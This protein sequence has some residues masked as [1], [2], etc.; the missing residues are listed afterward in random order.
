M[1]S[2]KIDTPSTTLGWEAASTKKLIAF[3]IPLI[4][5]LVLGVVIGLNFTNIIQFLTGND[6]EKQTDDNQYYIGK[7]L[8]V[9]W[10]IEKWDDYRKYTHTIVTQDHDTFWLKSSSINLVLYEGWASVRGTIEEYYDGMYI[11]E[12]E[13]AAEALGVGI[14]NTGDLLSWDIDSGDVV[15]VS[16]D[17]SELYFAE[18]GL[19]FDVTDSWSYK[20]SLAGDDSIQLSPVTSTDPTLMIDYFKCDAKDPNRNCAALSKQFSQSAEYTVT[21]ANGDLY[22]KLPEIDRW[23]VSNPGLFGYFV[24]GAKVDKIEWLI[25]YIVLPNRNYVA[26]KVMPFA[27]KLCST[28]D[29]SMTIVDKFET[30][31]KDGA[32]LTTIWWSDVDNNTLLCTLRIDLS[33][34][35]WAEL[36]SLSVEWSDV[37]VDSK[38]DTDDKSDNDSKSTTVSN[39]S[40]KGE[41][42]PINKD[43]PYIFSSSR[44]HSIVFPSKNISFAVGTD[45]ADIDLDGVSC[46]SHIN[47]TSY[48]DEVNLDTNPSVQIFECTV[49]DSVKSF[50][51]YRYVESA[52]G[53]EFLIKVLNPA[54]QL[55]ADN[56]EI[57]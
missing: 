33:T 57:K 11:L 36:V 9:T 17:P 39:D 48:S 20:A 4:T 23:F 16:L 15:D 6:S 46:Y 8:T 34:D 40:Y 30:V 42:F 52:D 24:N 41:Q 22:Y 56:I 35:L 28:I 12:V 3:V 25:R 2:K 55:F 44:G 31:A 37:D 49:R 43:S 18:A 14:L 21:S 32:L 53:K 7:E 29:H 1:E 13:S 50:W 27:S 5:V 19:L 26:D 45:D 38:A 54:W 10:L 51:E 47:V